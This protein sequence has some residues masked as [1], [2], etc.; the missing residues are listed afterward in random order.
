MTSFERLFA[1]VARPSV[2]YLG[3]ALLARV[4]AF[5]LVPLYTRRLSVEE[6]GQY[7][8]FLTLLSFLSTFL[9]LGLVGAITKFYFSAADRGQGRL[10][11]VSV[12]RWVVVVASTGGALLAVAV[13]FI[14]PDDGVNV[15][16]RDV[17]FL[18]VVGGVG[19]AIG[20]IP[21]VVLRAEQRPFAAAAFQMVQF[22]GTTGAGLV[23]VLLF[24]RG[25]RGALEAAAAGQAVSGIAALAY[26]VVLPRAPMSVAGLGA[27]LGFGLPFVPHF[28][29]AWLQSAAD[30]WIMTGA[31]HEAELGEYSLATQVVSPAGMVILAYNDA[32]GPRM[33][34]LY[35]QGGLSAVRASLREVR[36]RFLA[37]VAGVGLLLALTLPLV[38]L[39]IGEEF[40]SALLLVPLLLVTLVP[41]PALYSADYH[42]VYYAGRTKVLGAAT[43]AAAGTNIVLNLLLIPAFGAWGAIGARFCAGATRAGIVHWAARTVEEAERP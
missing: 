9:S 32:V 30:R 38:G 8:L 40:R 20:P 11:A 24:D 12:A 27:A 35:R 7:G 14:V 37:A 29:A 39:L 10:Q 4:G 34:E 15:W 41:D 3:A 23:L 26:I 13:A 6:Y 5:F 43:V 22:V 19:M 2:V 18:A 16:S 36:L 31:G 33:G 25:Y 21:W 42:V 1:V 28:L 17:L